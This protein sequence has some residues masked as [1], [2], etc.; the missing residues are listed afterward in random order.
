MESAFI[1]FLDQLFQEGYA[2]DFRENNPDAYYS[3]LA[4]FE[5]QYSNKHNDTSYISNGSRRR[6]NR[7]AANRSR[8]GIRNPNANQR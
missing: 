3:Q 6:Q 1:D 4:E 7:P 8:Q 2:E 5:N